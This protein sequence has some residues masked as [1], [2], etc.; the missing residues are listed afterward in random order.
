MKVAVKNLSGIA[1]WKSPVQFLANAGRSVAPSIVPFVAAFAVAVM[2][3]TSFGDIVRK[4]SAELVKSDFA[5]FY[6]GA[7]VSLAQQDP[8]ALS[9][10][11]LCEAQ[12]VDRPGGSDPAAVGVDPDPLPGYD[13]AF[14]APFT[15]LPYREAA[16][17]WDAM[18]VVAIVGTAAIM[19]ALTG[20]PLLVVA[21][22][23]AFAEGAMSIPY[24]Q[25]PPVLIFGLTL[26][27]YGLVR[28]R[29]A[30]VFGGVALAMIEPHVGFST[31]CA[32]F[33]WQPG[34]RLGL[35]GVALGLAAVSIAALGIP[36]NVEYALIALPAHAHAEATTSIQYS[37]TWLLHYI[38]LSDATA[39][40]WA[41]L[42]YGFFF[43][44]AVGLAGLVGRKLATPAAIALFPPAV[45][46]IGG[47][48]IHLHQ[49][50]AAIPFALLLATH[51]RGRSAMIAWAAT[52]LLAVPWHAGSFLIAVG[53]SAIVVTV[54]T[55]AFHNYR[56]ALAAAFAVVGIG[57]Y[58]GISGPVF[59][60][61]VPVTPQRVAAAALPIPRTFD[62]DRVASDQDAREVRT[63]DDFAI[64]TPRTLATKV[65]TWLALCTLA[66]V[67]LAARGRTGAAHVPASLGRKHPGHHACVG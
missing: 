34:L 40:G 57:L 25:L 26:A 59:M 15:A 54:A 58:L 9:P 50:A 13:M 51:L 10:L 35:A 32:I 60:H 20:L 24:G 17:L 11:R 44:V 16:L 49:I 14:F 19:A 7:L 12:L 33:V 67:T 66:L 42:Q 1:R 8:Y 39:I 45:V 22:I 18:L 37:L 65:P 64:A 29:R 3:Y 53:A 38:G 6:C 31:C 55:E 2:V 28:E 4:P 21:A 48:F 52:G 43:V 41:S 61:L 56:P 30:L 23:V 27:A 62:G 36:L 46:L 47:T 63:F 5:A